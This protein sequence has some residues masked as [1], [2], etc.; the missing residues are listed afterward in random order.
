MRR[1]QRPSPPTTIS[2]LALFVALGG[3]GYAAVKID[4]KN[5]KNK[6]ISAAKLKNNTLTGS[7]V[8][9]SKLAKVPSAATAD[10]AVSATTAGSAGTA[11]T[12]T[13]ADSAT[14]AA[15]AGSAAT[16]TTAN[17]LSAAGAAAFVP[18]GRY[19]STNGLGKFA[20][21]TARAVVL[22][23]GPFTVDVTCT[24]LGANNVRV[25]VGGK[26]TEANSALYTSTLG[27]DNIDVTS[28]SSAVFYFSGN[29]N[30]NFAAP[31]GKVLNI[32]V[33]Y[34]VKGLGTD[35]FFSADGF[36]SP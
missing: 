2:L 25:R 17:G 30:V 12:A 22:T 36:L 8:N 13:K 32:I 33:Q 7:Q 35:C 9:E 27:Q 21:G 31:S 24:D 4:G 3:T 28:A 19:V 1:F 20:L 18:A 29:E 5:I 14:T 34:G 26:S 11:A 15:T 23:A 16:A 10:R 6:T